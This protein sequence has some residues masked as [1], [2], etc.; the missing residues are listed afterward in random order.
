MITF[1]LK[2]RPG[3]PIAVHDVCVKWFVWELGSLHARYM[4]TGQT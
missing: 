4:D 3:G 1:S 2:S